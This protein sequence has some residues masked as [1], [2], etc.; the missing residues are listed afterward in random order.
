M[1]KETNRKERFSVSKKKHMDLNEVGYVIHRT[2]KEKGFY[3][4]EVDVN[5]A[6]SKIAL[7]HS[8]CTEVL[9]AI[10]KDQ[11]EEK[12]MEEIADVAIRLLDFVEA[13]KDGGFVSKDALL[14]DAIED[15]MR[16]NS[17]R[18]TKHGNLA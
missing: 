18:P 12:I 1:D 16:V 14:H 3:E 4:H 8:E 6:L 15:K 9:E 11:G 10:R 2:S 7:I 13:L 5:F 17:D